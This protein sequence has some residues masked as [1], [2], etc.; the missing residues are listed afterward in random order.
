MDSIGMWLTILFFVV[1]FI[2]VGR[3]IVCWYWKMNEVVKLL[4]RIADNLDR[5]VDRGE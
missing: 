4:T 1:L 2:I 5:L 3:E